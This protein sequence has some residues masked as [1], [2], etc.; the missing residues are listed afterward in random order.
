[1][2]YKKKP[3]IKDIELLHMMDFI[4][5]L[6]DACRVEVYVGTLKY[7]TEVHG[8]EKELAWI[9]ISEDFFDMSRFA[10]E[11]NIGHI[12]EIIKHNKLL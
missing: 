10:G 1:M 3:N 6:K 11:G 5:Y 12:L 7:E 9:D 2:N 8:D 4:Y